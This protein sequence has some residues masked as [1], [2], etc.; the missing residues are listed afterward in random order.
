MLIMNLP[1][2]INVLDCLS[3]F[4]DVEMVW[5]RLHGI[6]ILLRARDSRRGR[7]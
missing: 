6:G 7:R 5:N 1:N 2:S 4:Y 3:N